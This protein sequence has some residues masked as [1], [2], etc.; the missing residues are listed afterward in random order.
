MLSHCL[1]SLFKNSYAGNFCTG[2]KPT[3]KTYEKNP[4]KIVDDKQY[5]Q[6]EWMLNIVDLQQLIETK[7]AKIL[8]YA[9]II[10]KQKKEIVITSIVQWKPNIQRIF[11]L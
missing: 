2:L 5:Q 3:S 7:P 10:V 9:I 4:L 1:F 8:I 6:Y 11:L